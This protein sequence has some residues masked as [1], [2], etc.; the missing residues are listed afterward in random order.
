MVTAAGW[1]PQLCRHVRLR[2]QG[3]GPIRRRLRDDRRLGHG[4]LVVRRRVLELRSRRD[5]GRIDARRWSSLQRAL[6]ASARQVPTCGSLSRRDA[7]LPQRRRDVRLFADRYQLQHQWSGRGGNRSHRGSNE[8]ANHSLLTG[9]GTG[10]TTRFDLKSNGQVTMA[11][12]GSPTMDGRAAASHDGSV[13][14]RNRVTGRHASGDDVHDL[15]G[16]L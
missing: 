11:A 10:G 12:D 7:S 1:V 4:G 9:V 14:R 3:R 16:G 6:S 15:C 8:A 2:L 5:V 13:R